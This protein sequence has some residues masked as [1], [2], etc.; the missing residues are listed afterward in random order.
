MDIL[1]MIVAV[2][3]LFWIIF[4]HKSDNKF[5]PTH[6]VKLLMNGEGLSLRKKPNSNC[7]V[8]LK[9]E[10]GMKIQHLITGEKVKLNEINGYWYLIRTNNNK[11]GWC[12]SGSLEIIENINITSLNKR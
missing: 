5:I 12:F 10:N 8:F 1:L 9:I 11:Q 3:L 7:V 4:M 2:S 6:T